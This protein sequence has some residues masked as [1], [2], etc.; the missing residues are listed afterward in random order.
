MT[1]FS[2]VCLV[3]D[4]FCVDNDLLCSLMMR[5]RLAARHLLRPATMLAHLLGI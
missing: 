1:K 3:L 2:L 5:A 4:I